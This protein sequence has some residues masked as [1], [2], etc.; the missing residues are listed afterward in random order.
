NYANAKRFG[1]IPS[2]PPDGG[3]QGPEPEPWEFVWVGVEVIRCGADLSGCA[4]PPPVKPDVWNGTYWD[5]DDS[6]FED[7]I[8]ALTA[9]GV[10]RGCNP[11]HNDTI[12]VE[13]PVTR[14]EAAA[15]LRRSLAWPVG[16]TDF[17]D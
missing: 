8:E 5:D 12:C 10:L 9:L 2:Y 3:K 15:I 16:D 13:Y 14:G 6:V 1:F 11:P 7:D 4:P 17:G